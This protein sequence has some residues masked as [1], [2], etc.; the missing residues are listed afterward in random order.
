MS[1]PSSRSSS[2]KRK[3]AASLG[4]V[5][6]KSST[7][8]LQQPSSRD[9]SGEDADDLPTRATKH[10][11]SDNSIEPAKQ[12]KRARTRGAEK[13]LNEEQIQKE[14]TNV[15]TI[16]AEDPGE[17]SD[18]TEDSDDI[19]AK[20][21]GAKDSDEKTA[22]MAAPPKAGLQDPVGYKTNPPPVGRP[23]RVYA[24]GVFDLFHLG[25]VEASNLS[26]FD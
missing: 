10:R 3:R 16:N 7:I 18:P 2:A 19:E 15:P 5:H 25:Y 22:I 11:K 9:A 14:A 20:A 6:L 23:V 24:D 4:K 8:E 12:P 13:A 26:W 1:S 17:P 21:N